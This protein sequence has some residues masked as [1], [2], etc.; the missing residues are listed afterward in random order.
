MK[1]WLLLKGGL[2]AFASPLI[3]SACF[4]AN[5]DKGQK[6]NNGEMLSRGEPVRPGRQCGK[7][8]SDN[9]TCSVINKIKI[10]NSVHKQT[11]SSKAFSTSAKIT[12]ELFSDEYANMAKKA[13]DRYKKHSNKHVYESAKM[14]AELFSDSFGRSVEEFKTKAYRDSISGLDIDLHPTSEKPDEM[15]KENL[16]KNLKDNKVAKLMG[17]AARDAGKIFDDTYSNSIKA[18]LDRQRKKIE[19]KKA[20]AHKNESAR[21]TEELFS[22]SFGRAIESVKTK[23]YRDSA[24]GLDI[25]VYSTKDEIVKKT[26]DKNKK[27][28]EIARLSGLSARDTGKIFDDTYTDEIKRAKEHEQWLKQFKEPVVFDSRSWDWFVK[29]PELD[30]Y[31]LPKVR[32]YLKRK[33]LLQL[34]KDIDKKMAEEIIRGLNNIINNNSGILEIKNGNVWSVDKKWY[35]LWGGTQYI[36]PGLTLNHSISNVLRRYITTGGDKDNNHPTIGGFGVGQNGLFVMRLGDGVFAIQA[37]IALKDGTY[38]NTIYNQIIDLSKY[39]K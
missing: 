26:L 14:T 39:L 31:W 37:R 17:L 22:D 13:V 32:T 2:L 21:M 24:S 27:D 33:V 1:K 18:A 9:P 29:D 7:V 36:I 6:E 34:N 23:I 4:V 38:S 28:N 11:D 15:V 20:E 35:S 10:D 12:G 30:K 16:Y 3:S 8:L 19:A 5:I 25:N